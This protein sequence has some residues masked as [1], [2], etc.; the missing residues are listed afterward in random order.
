MCTF[1]NGRGGG[2]GGGGGGTN[3]GHLP[4][5]GVGRQPRHGHRRAPGGR[6]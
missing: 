2:G 5:Y 3:P 4:L 1:R 6:R